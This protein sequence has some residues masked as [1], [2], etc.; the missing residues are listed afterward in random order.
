MDHFASLVPNHEYGC[1][2]HCCCLCFREL[3]FLII[4][5]V[6]KK[7]RSRTR[8]LALHCNPQ[9]VF[10]D[11]HFLMLPL[12][13]NGTQIGMDNDQSYAPQLP[14]SI[15]FL[16]V[17]WLSCLQTRPAHQRYPRPPCLQ[18]PWPRDCSQHHL[19]KSPVLRAETRPPERIACHNFHQPTSVSDRSVVSGFYSC[20]FLCADFLNR[21]CSIIF[22]WL[23]LSGGSNFIVRSHPPSVGENSIFF[24]VLGSKLKP[25]LC[26]P[27][28]THRPQS[29]ISVTAIKGRRQLIF[30]LSMA[31]GFPGPSNVHRILFPWSHTLSR[32]AVLYAHPSRESLWTKYPRAAG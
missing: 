3:S 26:G 25:C 23:S 28:Q 16:V 20:P 32:P 9:L 11:G 1:S 17:V 8:L 21:R 30:L 19:L 22:C 14:V 15:A 10:C 7:N 5:T 24:P 29:V 12:H 31:I 27:K 2:A 13:N 18:G 4:S 6:C